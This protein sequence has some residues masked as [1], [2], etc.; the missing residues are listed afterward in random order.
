MLACKSLSVKR[1]NFLFIE[2]I[3]QV[4]TFITGN[5]TRMRRLPYMPLKCYSTI[6]KIWWFQIKS[7]QMTIDLYTLIL[8]GISQNALPKIS[9]LI[10]LYSLE[11]GCLMNPFIFIL[12]GC[13]WNWPQNWNRWMVLSDNLF[14]ILG[15][16][17]W[18]VLPL[19]HCLYRSIFIL[20]Q[21]TSCLH[22]HMKHVTYLHD[23]SQLPAWYILM[24]MVHTWHML[25]LIWYVPHLNEHIPYHN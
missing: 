25:Y 5:T 1:E 2:I 15:G 11:T 4:P 18:N 6:T 14:Q 8:G 22:T 16:I 19:N 23:V 9:T 7:N 3:G 13:L 24:I 17:L 12:G 10:D 21:Y 20:L